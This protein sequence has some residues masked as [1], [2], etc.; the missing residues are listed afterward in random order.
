MANAMDPFLS[1]GYCPK[2]EARLLAA[3]ARQGSVK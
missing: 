3:I 1:H 2:C